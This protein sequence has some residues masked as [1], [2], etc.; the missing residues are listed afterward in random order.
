MAKSPKAEADTQ[1]EVPSVPAKKPAGKKTMIIIALMFALLGSGGTWLVL[2]FNHPADGEAQAQPVKK[3][4]KQAHAG[5]SP[6]YLPLEPFVVNLRNPQGQGNDQ[7]LQ[8]DMTLRLAGQDGVDTIKAHMPE[9]RNRIL[10]L[11]ANKTSQ[12]VLTTEGKVKLAEAVRLEITA[13]VDPDAI[14]AAKPVKITKVAAGAEA[15]ESDEE[16]EAQAGE[17]EEAQTPEDFQ[18]KSVLF[19]SFIIQ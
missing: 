13:V 8:T 9:V 2:K 5:G 14:P 1:E 11:L 7:F 16:P 12:E 17:D 18:V 15:S 10:M 6:V 4:I 19:T 3:Q